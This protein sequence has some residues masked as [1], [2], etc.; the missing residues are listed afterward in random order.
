MRGQVLALMLA[1][2]ASPALGDVLFLKGGGRVTGEIV[3]ETGE[4]MTVDIGAGSMTVPKSSVVRVEKST[5]PLQQYRAR[6]ASLAP[7]DVEGWRKLG[8]WAAGQG[9]ATQAREAF[10]RVKEVVPDDPEANQALGL[11][12]HDGRWVTEKESLTARG[13]VQFEGEWMAPAERQAILEERRAGEEADRQALDAQIQ[14]DQAARAEEETREDAERDIWQGPLDQYRPEWDYG[15]YGYGPV[16]W[17][18]Q[19]VN[20]PGSALPAGRRE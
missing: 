8:R 4:A 7:G 6:A 16:V 2:T 20:L 10:T 14:A 18:A 1:L 5:S 19:P 13:F 11:V 3:K 9:L 12:L 15:A 17:P